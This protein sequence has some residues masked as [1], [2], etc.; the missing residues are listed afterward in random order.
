MSSMTDE[1]A[2]LRID[3]LP[4]Q[5]ICFD[6]RDLFPSGLIYNAEEARKRGMLHLALTA[7]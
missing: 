3:F 2:S 6:R 4:R 7:W 1:M 5:S